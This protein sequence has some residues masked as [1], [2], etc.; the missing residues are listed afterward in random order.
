MHNTTPKQKILKNVKSLLLITIGVMSASFGLESFL[1]PN[2]F[3]DGG[4]T[5]I[6]M[7]MVHITG[8]PLYFWIIL[9]NLPFVIWGGIKINIRFAVLSIIAIGMLA[10]SIAYFHF[11][12]ITTDTLLIAIFGGFFLGMGIGFAVRGSSVIDGTEVLA[13]SI[14]KRSFLSIGDTILILNVMIFSVAGYLLGVETALYSLL[15]YFVASKTVDFV[16]HGIEEYYGLTIITNNTTEV[17]EIL[18]EELNKSITLYSARGGR[19]AAEDDNYEVIY[20]I[21]TRLEVN[22]VIRK[23]LEVDEK[24]FIAEHILGEVHGG[25]VKKKPLH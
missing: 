15:T 9:I 22:R 17:K 11:P 16:I 24:A 25:V 3:I 8:W 2:N 14:S 12:I 6:S 13:L 21:V 1:I 10:F 18:T 20:V 4:V 23:V 7:L 19:S 5:G